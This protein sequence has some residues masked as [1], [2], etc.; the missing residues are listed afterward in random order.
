MQH[1]RTA[2]IS[3]GVD[4]KTRELLRGLF[5]AVDVAADGRRRVDVIFMTEAILSDTAQVNTYRQQHPNAPLVVVD[6]NRGMIHPDALC[7]LSSSSFQSDLKALTLLLD[8]QESNRRSRTRL[9]ALTWGLPALFLLASI[10]LWE[11]LTREFNIAVYVLP[12][13]AQIGRAL[14]T[15]RAVFINDAWVTMAESLGGFTLGC[16]LAFGAGAAMVHSRVLERALYPYAIALK[17][18]PLIAIAPLLVLWMG[19]GYPSKVAMAALICFFPVLVNTLEGL[20]ATPTEALAVMRSLAATPWQ[21]F[22]QLRLPLAIPYIFAGLKI[23]T[24][25]SVIGAVVAELS[26]SKDGI[27]HAILLYSGQGD[28]EKVFAGVIVISMASLLFFGSISLLEH[29]VTKS[30]RQWRII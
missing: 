12:S 11:L 5:D 26:G 18:V 30:T 4:P 17:T 13:P 2:I 24:T 25:L 1:K 19:N 15:G 21:V 20:R 29:L 6:T 16:G 3:D 28:T 8:Y 23:S 7:S 10:G 9:R 22:T 14:Y 27:G